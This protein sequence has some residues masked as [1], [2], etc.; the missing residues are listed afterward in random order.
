M[1][2]PLK[3]EARIPMVSV[4]MAVHN[5]E[6]FVRE[7]IDSI[8]G[9]SWADFELIV[10]DDAST[11]STPAILADYE[12]PRI[13]ILTDE[14][15]LGP[16]GSA[17]RG[18][19]VARGELVA[20][21][22]ADDV[23]LPRRLEKQVARFKQQPA[24]VL[25]GTGYH[26]IDEQG[27][28][29]DTVFLPTTNAEL[30]KRLESGNSFVHSTIMVRRTA[31]E[32]VGGY[33]DMFFVSQDYDM[34][35]RVR[36]WAKLPTSTTTGPFRFHSKSISRNREEL[37]LACRR[38]AWELA[39]RRRTGVEADPGRCAERLSPEAIRLFRSAHCLPIL[40]YGQAWPGA[41]GFATGAAAS[42]AGAGGGRELGGM[43]AGARR[44]P[45][46]AP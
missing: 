6:Q 34:Y 46:G 37:Q 16:Y 31:L 13:V 3:P 41:S 35:L 44:A 8:L 12:D 40:C 23:S 36:S 18:L 28:V 29:L 9:Q 4:I 1:S 45:C 10:V 7:A 11:D 15:N 14:A 24:L 19:T 43:V 22:D 32:A 26:L 5:S 25:L 33:R 17:N 27:Q 21:I 38:L 2:A 42:A 39:W 30:Q 20:R